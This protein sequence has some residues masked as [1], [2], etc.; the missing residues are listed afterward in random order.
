MQHCS[1]NQADI[2]L[3]PHQHEL[4]ITFVIRCDNRVK[5]TPNLT[6]VQMGCMQR[7]QVTL[8]RLR[9]VQ[10]IENGVI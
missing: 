2:K 4:R 5:E 8:D 3:Q 7:Q 6:V 10:T 9:K 1:K